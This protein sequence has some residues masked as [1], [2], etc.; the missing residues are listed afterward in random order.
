MTTFDKLTLDGMVRDAENLVQA[1][2]CGYKANVAAL[3]PDLACHVKA[4]ASE[5]ERLT[6][7][8]SA[9]AALCRSMKGPCICGCHTGTT[10]MEEPTP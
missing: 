6:E 10:T 8:H 3:A 1:V 9:L 2:Q 4:L 7:Y 5:V